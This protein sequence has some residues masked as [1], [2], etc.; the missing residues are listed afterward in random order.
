[1]ALGSD[2]EKI[3]LVHDAICEQT[4]YAYDEYNY[5][6]DDQWAHTIEG[7]FC[8]QKSAVCEGQAKAFSAVLNEL[9]I[10]NTI[11]S[12]IG[13]AEEDNGPHAWNAVK[14][15]GIWY[16]VDVTWDNQEPNYN[17]EW[18]L[19]GTESFMNSHVVTK[20]IEFHPTISAKDY[21]L[22][23]SVDPAATVKL[24]V[25]QPPVGTLGCYING[26]RIDDSR[27]AKGSTVD[28]VY[29]PNDAAHP[30]EVCLNGT[31]TDSRRFY[32]YED[33]EIGISGLDMTAIG[34]KLVNKDSYVGYLH[35][36]GT[37]IFSTEIMAEVTMRYDGSDQTTTDLFPAVPKASELYAGTS[38]ANGLTRRGQITF[39]PV[40][41]DYINSEGT[42]SQRSTVLLYGTPLDVKVTT[43]ADIT[44]RVGYEPYNA[45]II[46]LG[47][48]SC[49][50][51][52]SV[53][54]IYKGTILTLPSTVRMPAETGV[55]SAY[56]IGAAY[57]IS[58]NGQP[59]VGCSGNIDVRNNSELTLLPSAK[60]TE[61]LYTNGE[62]EK[63]SISNLPEIIAEKAGT[64][65]EQEK[66]IKKS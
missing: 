14:L 30:G 53:Q 38:Y 6:V 47:N 41:P 42:L 59:P 32:I 50:S 31:P 15:E 36:D 40:I 11:I 61:V 63:V 10:E 44:L 13:G 16:L 56:D 29:T 9:G 39:T 66:N 2:Y 4:V 23:Q 28:I 5:P 58:E 48:I 45:D 37:Y 54:R 55:Y 20:Y 22:P 27:V 35:N 51:G 60:V 7:V 64:V 26:V 1:M 12:G 3:K 62:N 24:T 57:T 18:F 33:T 19:N 49:P 52:S 21:Q 25:T 65:E 8:Q 34:M 43:P 46:S 17:Y